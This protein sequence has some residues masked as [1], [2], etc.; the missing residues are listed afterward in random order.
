MYVSVSTKKVGFRSCQV[1]GGRNYYSPTF[2]IRSHREAWRCKGG[3]V[4]YHSYPHPSPWVRLRRLLIHT[5][6]RIPQERDVQCLGRNNHTF[7][8]RGQLVC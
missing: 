1:L 6:T 7:N 5:L 4:S 2:F 3:E 8:F